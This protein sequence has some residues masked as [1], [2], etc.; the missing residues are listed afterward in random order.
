MSPEF[1]ARLSLL[2]KLATAG[3]YLENLDK[4]TRECASL[5]QDRAFPLTFFI[6]K[7]IFQDTAGIVEREQPLTEAEQ[8]TLTGAIQGQALL[9][10]ETLV[11]DSEPSVQ[12]LNKLVYAHLTSVASFKAMQ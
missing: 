12:D 5:A 6:L 10:F 8:A 9:I 3:L 1:H 4:L 2:R 7:S 11:H